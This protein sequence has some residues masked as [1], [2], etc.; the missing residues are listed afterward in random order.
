M[1]S[2]WFTDRV[3]L[4]EYNFDTRRADV[5]TDRILA[6]D[7]RNGGRVRLVDGHGGPD[8]NLLCRTPHRERAHT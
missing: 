2:V 1:R 7:H 8:W 6:T 3:S 4:Y 5:D